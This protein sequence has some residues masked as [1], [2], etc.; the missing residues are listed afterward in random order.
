MNTSEQGLD[1]FQNFLHFS[2]MDISSVN[3]KNRKNASMLIR[4]QQSKI[5]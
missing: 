2:A 3:H 1:G 5:T 4:V